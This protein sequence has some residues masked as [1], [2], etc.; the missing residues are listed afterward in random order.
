[1][2]KSVEVLKA[3]PEQGLNRQKQQGLPEA[4][5]PCEKNLCS[6]AAKFVEEI[7]F[8]DVNLIES[9]KQNKG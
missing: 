2:G 5:R 9:T 8:V 6:L 1:M 3:I 7:C 4:A